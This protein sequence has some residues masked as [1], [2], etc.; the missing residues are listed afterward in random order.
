MLAALLVIGLA[1]LLGSIP[2]GVLLSRTLGGRDVR[3]HGSGN[4][5]AAN[6]VR[7]SGFKVGA[8]VGL[9]DILKGV[10]PILVGRLAGVDHTG[11]A[12]VAVV[13]VLGHDFSVFLRFRGGKGVS[14][15]LGAALALAPL[16]A[17]LAML[18]WLLIMYLSRYSSLASLTA[19]ALLPMFLVMT[20]QPVPYIAAGMF[21]FALGVWKHRDNIGRLAAGKE[22]KF[23]RLKP[24]NES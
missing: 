10:A 4:I 3:Q 15:T 16:A 9:I 7:T 19:L 14:T 22:S 1:F 6:V 11:L 17:V 12:I 2:T 5:G 13:A 23:R 18:G 8:L 24:S 21:L 20:A